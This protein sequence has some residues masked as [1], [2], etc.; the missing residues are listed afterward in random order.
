MVRVTEQD[1]QT[2]CVRAV[3]ALLSL[4]AHPHF[5]VLTS[6]FSRERHPLGHMVPSGNPSLQSW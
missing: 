2:L 3:R 4:T 6:Q 1:L 5:S